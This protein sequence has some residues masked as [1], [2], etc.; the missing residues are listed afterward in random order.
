MNLPPGFL[1]P[2]SKC[3]AHLFVAVIF[4]VATGERV[5]A[6]AP[7]AESGHKTRLFI[8][9]GQSNM[10]HLEPDESFTPAIKKAFPGDTIIVV[11]EAESGQPIRRWYRKWKPE[12]G[13]VDK[14]TRIGDLYKRLMTEVAA[15][16]EGKPVPDTVTFVWMQGEADTHSPDSANVYAESL[17][18]LIAQLRE[19]LK[20]PD[21]FAVIG[22]ISDYN[23]FPEGTKTIRDAEMSVAK[24]DPLAGWIDTD[25]L[26]GKNDGL[27]YTTPGYQTLGERFAA[28]A[29]ELIQGQKTTTFQK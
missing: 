15:A 11:K 4:A 2:I 9:S 28:K 24:G 19:D 3:I 6:G 17:K 22:R 8:L 5:H 13:E 16:Q 27:H 23:A 12:H 14:T 26:N 25:D 1:R 7:L 20:R 29:V 21:T 10:K 18:G